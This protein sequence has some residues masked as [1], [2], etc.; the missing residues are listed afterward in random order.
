[1]ASGEPAAIAQ[2]EGALEAL[3]KA[4]GKKTGPFSDASPAE[5]TRRFHEANVVHGV[6]DKQQKVYTYGPCNLLIVTVMATV[7][8][9]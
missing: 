2:A 6:T 9:T 5:A 4:E 1:M 3:D 8:T 7:W